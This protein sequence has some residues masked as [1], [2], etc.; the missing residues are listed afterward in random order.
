MKSGRGGFTLV[1][2]LL[3]VAILGILST[4]SVVAVI[5]HMDKAREGATL[6][7]INTVKTVLNTYYMDTGSFPAG[8][9]ATGVSCRWC[10]DG[11]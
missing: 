9:H 3:V 7:T 10:A 6:T 11:P 4:I 5:R 2:V 8:R 1:E